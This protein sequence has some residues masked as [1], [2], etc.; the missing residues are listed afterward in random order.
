MQ[1]TNEAMTVENIFK[2]ELSPIPNALFNDEG[3][4][5]AAKSKSDLKSL[6]GT[7]VSSFDLQNQT[8]RLLM[9]QLYCGL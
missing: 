3:E 9:S 1:L 6:L 5:R 7:K 4:M 8:L 2:Y